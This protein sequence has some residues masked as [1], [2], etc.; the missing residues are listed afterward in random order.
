[1]V[2]AVCPQWSY[3]VPTTHWP[4]S[5]SVDLRVQ[6]SPLE[7][8]SASQPRLCPQSPLLLSRL[9][10]EPLHGYHPNLPPPHAYTFSSSHTKP[11]TLNFQL[12]NLLARFPNR[13]QVSRMRQIS[14]SSPILQNTRALEEACSQPRSEITELR[15]ADGCSDLSRHHPPALRPGWGLPSRQELCCSFSH[16]WPASPGAQDVEQASSHA[17][18]TWVAT[19]HERLIFRLC[20]TFSHGFQIPALDCKHAA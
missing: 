1:M 12:V 8:P 4:V 10:H 19:V 15:G 6:L 18:K 9:L 11:S 7:T 2:Q 5:L 17:S 13:W 14:I 16:C 20:L 3:Q